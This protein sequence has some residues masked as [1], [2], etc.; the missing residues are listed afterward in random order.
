MS[1]HVSCSH[2]P[3]HLPENRYKG[4]HPIHS[5]TFLFEV[6]LIKKVPRRFYCSK[7]DDPI[8]GKLWANQRKSTILSPIKVKDWSNQ[9]TELEKNSCRGLRAACGC[10]SSPFQLK[11]VSSPSPSLYFNLI[12]MQPIRL[13]LHLSKR[14]RIQA[15]YLCIEL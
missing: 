8:V 15:L 9:M 11:W 14:K 3:L 13:L 5:I 4:S 2:D 7:L 1:C 12:N 6:P 10:T